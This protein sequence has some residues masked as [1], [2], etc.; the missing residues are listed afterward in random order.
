MKI[1]NFGSLNLDYV[2]SLEHFVTPGETITAGDYKV[3]AGGKGLN[4]S[5]ALARAGA[6][7]YHAG[8][9]GNEG[10]Q[11]I[12][13]LNESGAKTDYIKTVDTATGH[14]IIQVDSEGQNCIIIFGGANQKIT[15]DHIKEALDIFCEGD[16][17]VLQ[18]ETNALEDLINAAYDKKMKIA[19]NP[20]PFEKKL[21]DL[22]LQKITWFLVNEVEGKEIS[23]ESDPQKTVSGIIAKYPS[24]EV[25]LTLGPNGVLYGKGDLRIAHPAHKA[26]VLDTTAAGDTFTGYF[27]YAVS[28]G[29][30]VEYALNLASAA[31]AYAIGI[32]GAAKSIPYKKDLKV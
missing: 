15:K 1:L 4:Q 18:N 21:L 26:K 10:E 9:V 5:I 19:F 8:C 31:S 22:P 20:S 7:V 30:S 24:A 32:K 12:E 13:L 14:A 3:N 6:E 16:I 27:L 28:S 23:G 11:L 25:V 17:L 2:Y 29:E